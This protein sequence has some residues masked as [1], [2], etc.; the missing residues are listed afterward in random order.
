[1]SHAFF[2]LHKERK[3]LMR[4][5]DDSVA[6]LKGVG[7]KLL[8]ELNK[9]GIISI[10]DLL[11]CFPFRFEDIKEREVGEILDGE[12]VVLKGLVV[13]EGIVT[14]FG[15]KK[16]R[17][18]FRLMQDGVVINVTFFNQPYLAQKI[19]LGEQLAVFGKWDAKRKSLAG[20]KIIGAKITADFQPIYH[21]GKNIP[22]GKLQK[23]ISQAF[24]LYQDFIPETLPAKILQ[25]YQFMP[26]KNALY[27]MH[28]PKDEKEANDARRRI[29]FEEFFYFQLKMLSL[30]GKEQ[31]KNP[32]EVTRYNNQA[33]KKYIQALPFE[34]TSAQ[35]KVTN[36]ICYDLLAPYHMQRLLQGDV[37]S[38][39]TVVASII[40]YAVYTAGRQSALM[41]PTEIL[42]QQH[43]A[44]FQKLLQDFPE[45]KIALLTSSTK[46]KEREEILAAL[47]NGQLH[48][49]IGTHALI[50]E[51]VVFHQLGLV[52]TDEQHRFGVNQRKALREKGN[53]PEVLFMT[54]T[55][56]PRTL[57]ITAY[58][59]M[60]VSLL[61]ELPKGR[62]KILTK[63]V[64]KEQL[65]TVLAY[66]KQRLQAGDQGYVLSPLIEESE[67]LDLQNAQAL[68]LEMQNYFPEFKVGLLHGQ[69]KSNEKDAVMELFKENQLQL[70][71]TTTVVEV[72]VDVPNATVMLIFD[73][74]RF[75]LSQLHQL[76]GRVGRGVKQSICVL[77]ADPKGE[78]GKQRMKIMTET[79][80]GF[81]LS[82]KDLEMRGPGEFF[83]N[84]QSGLPQFLVANLV[85]DA[86]S[87]EMA[88]TSAKEILEKQPELLNESPLKEGV[89]KQIFTSYF[90]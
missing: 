19:V 14:H 84:K 70:L 89:A 90:D 81:V 73:A 25:D 31:K 6:V 88:R 20:M 42:A 27:V 24:E 22:Q 69:M 29:V 35:K 62:Q 11:R 82:Q 51:D 87:L 38:G 50:Q 76:R 83:G 46:K 53:D 18:V 10:Y 26:L 67:V 60:D 5:I 75:G 57:A 17:L 49:I 13:S 30:K 7:P 80:D 45:V 8:S 44:T 65:P 58:G 61:N 9:A 1:M 34:L 64:K 15:Y 48:F 85:E 79:N 74:D 71:V 54:A 40:M 4:K 39:K 3:K 28:F 33:L 68:F 59:E 37:G 36:E 63:W 47:K 78:N 55:P 86:D 16:S 21:T 77:V 52:I 72:G 32:G 2:T 23:L 66:L 43:Y 12:K 41:V 56:I